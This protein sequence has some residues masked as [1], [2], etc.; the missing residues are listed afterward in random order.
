MEAALRALRGE[1]HAEVA[2]AGEQDVA[3]G[4]EQLSLHQHAAVAEQLLAALLV[5]LLQQVPLVGHR[6]VRRVEPSLGLPATTSAGVSGRTWTERWGVV[7]LIY[8]YRTLKTD[9]LV[10]LYW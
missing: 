9:F 8:G 10:L 5:Q 3:V 1:Q 6:D 4:S 2:A 7:I